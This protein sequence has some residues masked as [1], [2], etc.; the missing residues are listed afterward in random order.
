MRPHNSV[1]S[2]VNRLGRLGTFDKHRLACASRS[3]PHIRN[4]PRRTFAVNIP[5]AMIGKSSIP[6]AL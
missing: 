2:L 6:T 5:L 3:A 4:Y 1:S